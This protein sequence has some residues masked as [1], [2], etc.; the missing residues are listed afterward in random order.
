MATLF[1][2]A[3]EAMLFGGLL[4]GFWV[5]RLGSPVWPP[6]FEPRLPLGVTTANTLVLLASSGAVLAAREALR[7][8]DRAGLARGLAAGAVLGGLFLALQ[9]YEWLRFLAAGFT[10]TSG[11]YGALFYTLIGVHALHVAA[12]L[13]WLAAA[14]CLAGRRGAARARTAPLHACMLYWHFV[15]ALWPVLYV[16][17]YVL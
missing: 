14:A 11:T 2:I 17:V 3:S 6:L 4:F 15:V 5:L 12:A 13:A 16:C 9:G 1:L 10:V 8:E 7:R